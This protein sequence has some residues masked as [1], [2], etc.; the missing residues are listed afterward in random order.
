MT[1]VP[2]PDQAEHSEQPRRRRRAGRLSPAALAG[3]L[4]LAFLITH[5]M[6]ADPSGRSLAGNPP[7]EALFEWFI[8]R[9]AHAVLN[10][11]VSLITHLM[12]APRGV[13]LMANTS[14][15][16]PG[17]VVAPVTWLFGAS[18]SFVLLLTLGPALT[19]WTTYLVLRRFV[20]NPG[21]AVVGGLV[22]GFCPA[23]IAQSLGHLHMTLAFLIPPILLLAYDLVATTKPPVPIALRLAA[24]AIL[25]VFIGAEWL[26][27]AA[28][29]SVVALLWA[30]MSRPRQMPPV[31]LRLAYGGTI[32]VGVVL[33]VLSYPLWVMFFGSHAVHGSPFT[34]GYFSSDLQTYLLPSSLQY[35]G[36]A[37][38]KATSLALRG[39]IT[40]QNAAMGWPFLILLAVS[41]VV[42]RRSLLARTA[43]AVSVVMVV[44]SFG[45]TL[46]VNNK[47]TGIS[48]PWGKVARLPVFE[49]AVPIRFPFAVYLM[50][51]VLIALLIDHHTRGRPPS[52]SAAPLTGILVTLLLLVPRPLETVDVPPVPRFFQEDV[53]RVVPAGSTVLVV[54]IATPQFVEPMRW[55]VASGMHFAMPGGFYIGPAPDGQAFFNP[56]GRPTQGLLGQIHKGEA[57]PPLSDEVLTNADADL[58]YWA[59]THVVLAPDPK[60]A[61]LRTYLEAMIGAPPEQV[62][63]ALVWDLRDR[64]PPVGGG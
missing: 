34:F 3:Y 8:A 13:N 10:A 21:A 24:L 25:Q 11:D 40:E 32:A 55:Q 41:V 63:D 58:A 7:D 20:R 5:R 45:P 19:A 33:V 62:S 56:D 12:N 18:A 43:A 42:L 64:R 9:T 52:V 1:G 48:M 36:S 61:E 17:I 35:F 22:F 4:V 16:V 49:A 29:M 28:I 47:D 14:L 51:A 27:V 37:E 38:D 53:Q 57:Y 54:P 39:G 30:A 60:Q 23:M 44:L 46:V 31:A 26:F 50:A 6:W 2:E 59:A 15:I